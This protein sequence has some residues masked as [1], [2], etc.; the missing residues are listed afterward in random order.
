MLKVQ[1]IE[2]SAKQS[3]AGVLCHCT[4]C[5]RIFKLF[6]YHIENDTAFSEFDCDCGRMIRIEETKTHSPVKTESTWQILIESPKQAT[7]SRSKETL[8]KKFNISIFLLSRRALGILEFFFALTIFGGAVVGNMNPRLGAR[9]WVLSTRVAFHVRYS[10]FDARTVHSFL[11]GPF[12]NTRLSF[13]CDGE[14]VWPSESLK[15]L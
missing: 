13:S 2:M 15:K 4:N 1:M 9:F 11:C 10:L 3:A 14:N 7:T 5:H 8:L 12:Y 6:S